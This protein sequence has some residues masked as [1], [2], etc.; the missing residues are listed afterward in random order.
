MLFSLGMALVSFACG[1]SQNLPVDPN[2]KMGVLPNGMKYYIKKNVKPEKK[3]ELR[4]AI[5]TG[6]VMEDDD[7]LGLAHF[8][9]HMNFNG[10]KNFPGNKLVDYLQS[11]GIKF[12]QHL[13]AY[14]SFDE[15][16]YMLP[17]PL[18]K[19]ENL[20]TGL[21]VMEDWAFNALLTEK[22]I[23]KERGVVLEE[24]RLG[25]GP[26]KRMLEKYFPKI[27]YKSKYAE[28]LPIGQKKLLETFT[29]DKL[30]RFHT[31][32]YRPD[33]MALVV[34]GDI[35]VDDIEKKIKANFSSYKNPAK[36]RP[37]TVVEVPN[38]KETFVA[39]ESD[40]DA[41]N[42]MVQLMYN[43]TEDRKPILTES[44]YNKKIVETLF[45]TMLNNRLQELVNSSTPPFIYGYTAKE[46]LVRAKDAFM[47]MALTAEGKQLP[48]LKTLMEE[49]ERAR[50]FGFSNGE[51]ER[52][53]AE[54]L[55]QLEK[56][57]NNRDKQNSSSLVG[58]LVNNY[59]E[60][61]PIPGIEW[62]F[63]QHKKIL[64]TI[65]LEQVNNVVKDY[66][67]EDNRVIVLTGPKKDNLQQV[68]EKEV[69]SLFDVVKNDD[70]K[71]YDDQSKVKDLV[72]PFTSKGKIVKTETDGK[73]GTTTFTLNN[74]AKVT[75]K[76]TNF[77]ED[78]I[79]FSARSLGGI[80]TVS[81]SDY[82]KIQWALPALAEAG[83]NGYSK[84]DITKFMSGKQVDVNPSLNGLSVNFNGNSTKKDLETLFQM[85]YG[86]FT[87]LN[88]DPESYNSYKTKQKG[89]LDNI[90][91]N[92]QVFY[93]IEMQKHLNQKNPR[94]FGLLPDDKAWDKTDY[95]L[96]HE[97]YK[98][99]V[100]NAGNFHFYFVGNIDE[101][102]LKK[103]AEQ[104]LG[105]LP[106]TGKVETFKDS[107]YRPVN[108]AVEK[109]FKKG[110][111]P[112]SMVTIM[113]SGE[114]T[115]NEKE[116]LAL[117]ALGEVATIK[118]IEK[119][120]EEESGIYGGGAR[121]SL[122]KVPYGN[123]S[124][125]INFPC[126][127]ENA[128]KLTKSAI[129]ELQKLIDN[130]PDE[131]DLTKFK[132]GEATD[133]ITNMKDN[134]YWLRN[135]ANYQL[136]GGD[137]YEVLNY[138]DKVKALTVKDLQAVGK[139]YLNKNRMVFTLMPEVETPKTEK[140]VATS[141]EQSPQQ[142]IDKYITALGG[143]TKLEAV[144]SIKSEAKM[145]VM[146]MEMS[147]VTK[148][149]LPNKYR[150]EQNVMGQQMLQVFDG[151]KGYFSQ[152]GQKMD[153]PAPAI[154]ELKNKKLFDALSLKADDYK[155]VEAVSEGGKNYILLSSDKG[156]SY[157]DA[158]TGLLAKQT[159]EK[160]DQIIEE[161]MEVEGIKVPKLMK[162]SAMGQNFD[163]E[164]VSTVFN[165]DVSEQDFQ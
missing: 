115:Y 109:V 26:D 23:D 136:E 131:K 68:S 142:V 155:K 158:T 98:Q 107:G 38:H 140:K 72:A 91:S 7:Q 55:S 121:G 42:S 129:A 48:A 70:L 93:Q 117:R 144:K 31:D 123:Y 159:S 65:T 10:T 3:V 41:T 75:Y 34:V 74:G 21:K 20:D 11:I 52:A 89:F 18:D 59:L 67:R 133:D 106:S 50:R 124:F 5:N 4:L 145:K 66:V 119:L 153:L 85:V 6:S 132:E 19:P 139:K 110:K 101:T 162:V 56:K 1:F 134:R 43:D 147:M 118:I 127:P 97:I 104:Y 102:L 165:K 108:T 103:Y 77:K 63:N 12:G 88:Y 58:E 83:F 114:T 105:N 25:L 39:I 14:T 116:D 86:Y 64:P 154:E 151:E 71:P 46:S 79:V 81:N 2:V 122:N 125:S 62:E 87:G 84:N 49:T 78:E 44:D 137:K 95:K 29:Y 164:I 149:M 57:F 27:F 100:S 73:L 15:T 128:D 30:K 163:M 150:M 157:F 82:E 22:E 37:R 54:V 160:G 36:P 113:F 17:V 28:R 126:G 130:G 9:E 35:N 143:K 135:I 92:P 80:S 94:F 111:D 156:K 76:K 53:K 152:A 33:L 69:L 32:W 61:E 120:R 8:M 13:N 148:Q 45:S 141:T 47:S 51:L 138:M 96:A 161:Y 146:G 16:V 24:L 112:K 99:K 60:N 90:V 40:P